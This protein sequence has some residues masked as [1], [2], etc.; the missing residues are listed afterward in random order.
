[1]KVKRAAPVFSLTSHAA[2]LSYV[3]SGDLPQEAS[4]TAYVM[5]QIETL[6]DIFNSSGLCD[7]KMY[8]MALKNGSPAF[9]YMKSMLSVF[10][11]I[12]VLGVRTES[13][14]I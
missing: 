11:R 7:S 1:M 12:T 8:K 4:Y 14:C 13:P 10:K 2:L 9:D 3:C 6:F 5:K